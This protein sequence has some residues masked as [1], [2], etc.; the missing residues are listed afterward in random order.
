MIDPDVK[1][2]CDE[3]CTEWLK[4]NKE[5]INLYYLSLNGRAEEKL[6]SLANELDHL[7]RE[8]VVLKTQAETW[9]QCYLEQVR[10]NVLMQ[11]K[12]LAEGV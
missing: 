8:A 5:P 3:L 1:K 9:K 11:A 7:S 6:A 2:L 12:V 4:S 10:E